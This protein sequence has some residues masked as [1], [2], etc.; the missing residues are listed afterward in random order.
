MYVPPEQS[1]F[2]SADE[3]FEFQNDI[4]S[5][6]SGYEFLILT[7]DAN[8]HT[9]NLPDYIELDDF[10][11]NFLDL[12]ADT[13]SSFNHINKLV[14]LNI[15]RDRASQCSKV[16]NTGLKLLEICKN[17]NLF[18]MNGRIGNDKSRGMLTFRDKS[19]IDYSISSVNCL[20]HTS[21]FDVIEL[22]T[23]FS[24][25]HQLLTI[26]LSTNTPPINLQSFPEPLPQTNRPEKHP[27]W[28]DSKHNVFVQNLNPVYLQELNNLINTSESNINDTKYYVNKV[29]E[30][31]SRVFAES[32]EMTFIQGQRSNRHS[33]ESKT[34]SSKAWFGPQCRRARNSYNKARKNYQLHKN[35]LNKSRL[36]SASK[37]YKQTMNVFI[38]KHKLQKER[39]LRAM[40]SHKPRD[41][42]K[43]L[44]SLTPRNTEKTPTVSEFFDYFKN[45][46]SP[47]SEIDDNAPFNEEPL[48]IEDNNALNRPISEFEILKVIAKLNNGKAAS[49]FDNISNEYLKSTR[50]VM[51]PIY[52]KLFN[53]ILDSGILPDSWLIGCIKPIFKNK[54]SKLNPANYRPITILSCLGKVF[55]A[56]LN[57][58]INEFLADNNLLNENQAG[59]RSGYSTSDH[60]FTLHFLIEKL[61]SEKKKLLCSFID[62]SAAFDSVW[63]AGLW[64]KLSSTG[65]SGKILTVIKNM[66]SDIK[67]CVNANGQTSA[68][69]TSFTGVR[70]GE[71][72]SPILFSLYLNDLDSVLSRDN[73]GIIIDF[74]VN[75]ALHFLKLL[76]LLYADDTVIFGENE[77]TFQLCLDNF[78]NYCQKWKLK[79]NFS[80]TKVIVF[81]TNK[82]SKYSFN[83]NGQPIETVKEYK[84]LGVVFS[85]SGS[86]LSCRKHVVS[87]ANKAMHLLYMRIS[88][89]DLPIDLQLKLFDHTV[90]PIL[91]YGSEIW[92]FE[93]LDMVEQVHTNFLRKI[94]KTRKST[95]RYMLYGELGR[96]PIEIII[97]SRMVNFWNKLILSSNSKYS[98]N[99]Y[100]H[101]L[102]SNHIFKW[103]SFVKQIL[104]STGNSYLWLNQ[105]SL[106]CKFLNKMVKPTLVDQFFQDWCSKLEASSKGQMYHIFKEN[107]LF[108]E[109]FSI[110][111][112]SLRLALMHFRTGNHRFPI[113]VGRWSQSFIPHEQRKCN[114]CPLNDLGD[115]FHYLL[116]CP[117][118]KE[119][120]NKLLNRRFYN[121]PNILKFKEL[122]AT[123][124]RIQLT[125]LA[126]YVAFTMKFFKRS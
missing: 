68:F 104:D 76:L 34:C 99:C 8:G 122:L 1:R 87:Q 120:R 11:S 31:I 56:V 106:T 117:F 73:N 6:C 28:L 64:H 88:N 66:Y 18:I 48:I 59:F 126:K 86:F 39:K 41:Y 55:T 45:I 124:D 3:F 44:N 95:P 61:R 26:D 62:F 42:W 4:A 83:I 69:F 51:A 13:I 78:Y 105:R 107:T 109:Y 46:N 125:N 101:M 22:D 9:S 37:H 24:D 116:V 93:N 27:K 108:E 15:L 85:S 12:D 80:K 10:L 123:N 92:G 70:Q 36:K 84:Y 75:N 25:G 97:K 30:L 35:D 54:E 103:P 98:F 5:K 115:E 63:R 118:F 14:D 81:G 20:Q 121:N 90:L 58:R 65:I 38:N 91:T 16:N 19:I 43:Y 32:A 50:A 111:P 53:F 94:T 67:S 100:L 96:Y 21:N 114:L 57:N 29:T 77:S 2:F 110:L 23:L 33:D 17:N 7:G 49:Q 72:L 79:I 102:Q 112:N 52:V 89:L 82:P 113:E 60:I 74:H 47:H 40:S 71:N 119:K